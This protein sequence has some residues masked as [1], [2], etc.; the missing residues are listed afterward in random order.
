MVGAGNVARAAGAGAHA[1][2][3]LDHR[4][5][6]LGVLA[7]AEIIVRA[8]DHDVA[9]TRRAVPDGTGKTSRQPFK[10]G[11]HPVAAFVVQPFQRLIEETLVIHSSGPLFRWSSADGPN[12][13]L[14]QTRD[15]TFLDWF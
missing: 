7:H 4:A 2:R 5:D 15:E 14:G 11:K 10:I 6:H 8:P 9:R 13:D 12:C 1:R 3:G